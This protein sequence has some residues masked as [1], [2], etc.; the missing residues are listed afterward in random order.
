[1]NRFVAE[2][3]G[4]CGIRIERDV[5]LVLRDGLVAGSTRGACLGRGGEYS[6]GELASSVS[7]RDNTTDLY[8]E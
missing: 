5:E 6:V 3:C 1:M 2:S 7:Y 4:V 8:S